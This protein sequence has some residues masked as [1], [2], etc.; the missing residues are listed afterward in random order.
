MK[1]IYIT[2]VSGTGKSAIAKEL[3]KRGVFAF[4]IEEV[5]GMCYWVDKKTQ[6]QDINYSPTMD[7]LE[8][9]D[10]I[11]DTKKL[12]ELLASEKDIIIATG[13][14]GNQDEYLNLF[15]KIFLLQSE[16]ET[17]TNRM[18]SRHLQ[19]GENSYG[20][21]PAEREFAI[22]NYKNFENK[23][24]ALGAI[25]VNAELSLSEVADQILSKI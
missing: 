3:K 8:A 25:L 10:W 20:Q 23:M 15:D 21:Y 12:K 1:K 22:R 6:E 2:G 13:I 14:T 11:C 17:F 5:E 16:E 18:A 19:P 24:I 7:W 9:H 4:D